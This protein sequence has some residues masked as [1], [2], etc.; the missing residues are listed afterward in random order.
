MT[1]PNADILDLRMVDEYHSR[2]QSK[3]FNRR[4]AAWLLA[5]LLVVLGA[6]LW[7]IQVYGTAVPYW[8]QWDEARL[9]FKPWLEGHLTWNAWF[10]PHNEHRIF[11]TR[12]LDLL[13]LW[14]NRQWDPRL[15]MVINA[16]IHTGYACGLAYGLWIFT[17]R[18]HEGLICFL[19]MPFFA[20][21]FAAE[22]TIHGFHS[23]EYFLSIFAV[24]TIIGLGFGSPGGG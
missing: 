20:F 5:L 14:F 1:C 23:Q 10:A 8:D 12:A 2:V 3:N 15:Q 11:F 16:F 4:L 19:L 6:K 22:N 17:G 7:V 9:L 13:E 24:V 21:P 18:K